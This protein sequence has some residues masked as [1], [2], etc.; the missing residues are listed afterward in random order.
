MPAR[1]QDPGN[2]RNASGDRS[3][4]ALDVARGLGAS[5]LQG[6]A[7]VRHSLPDCPASDV[8]HSPAVLVAFYPFVAEEDTLKTSWWHSARPPAAEPESDAVQ[9]DPDV[10]PSG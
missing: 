6:W 10:T 7:S 8:P 2:T 1:R 9:S 3:P 4:S 5:R